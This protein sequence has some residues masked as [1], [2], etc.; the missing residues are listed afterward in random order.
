MNSLQFGKGN[1]FGS[2]PVKN[3]HTIVV[4]HIQG[5]L[6]MM[7]LFRYCTRTKHD[8]VILYILS[9]SHRLNNSGTSAPHH[10]R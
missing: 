8:F 4:R 10:E 7:F 9:I 6:V 2:R 5:I 1:R 3:C